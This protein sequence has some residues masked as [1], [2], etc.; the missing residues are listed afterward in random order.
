MDRTKR[1]AMEEILATEE[2]LIP[3]SGFTARVMEQV[4][5]EAAAPKPIPF[6]WRRAA[7]GVV[8]V[9]GVFAWVGVELT[10]QVMHAVR[11]G[12]TTQ[13]L[14]IAMPALGALGPWEWVTIAF[15]ITVASWI[16]AR[17]LAGSGSGGLL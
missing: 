7:V 12:T 15:G 3:S 5:E 13:S 4:R 8:L 6:P 14:P 1:D 2:A 16:L 11:T 10:R 9:V 17:R